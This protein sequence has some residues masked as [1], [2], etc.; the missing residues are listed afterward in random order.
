MPK[1][2]SLK[3]IKARISKLEAQ[4]RKVAAAQKTGSKAAI[5]LIKK[6][7]LSLS[8]ISAALGKSGKLASG[9]VKLSAK[10]TTKKAKI[11]FR[12]GEGN[13]WSGRGLTPKWLVAAEK[14]GKKRERFAV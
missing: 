11:K 2:L 8:D 10:R 3:T 5:A 6:H 1:A 7:K 13:V 12:D 9:S 4:A 14:T